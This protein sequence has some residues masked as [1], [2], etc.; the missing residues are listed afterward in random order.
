[1]NAYKIFQKIKTLGM[2]VGGCFIFI[3]MLYITLDVFLRN[4][5]GNSSLHAYEFS[6]YYFMPII[7]FTGLAYTFSAG[8]MPR[9][10]LLV[11]K[12]NDKYQR[13]VA[14]F[15]IILEIVL[16]LLL[17]IFGWQY[18]VY[19]FANGISFSAGGSNFA[20]APVIIFVP[21][22]FLLVMIEM[23]FLLIKNIKGSKASFVVLDEKLKDEVS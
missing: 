14:V 18:A 21:I 19:A 15:L 17:T 10:E 5:T 20:T 2:V 13:I 11:N 23:I 4:V 16:L 6:Q 7:V 1:M 9:V 12:L 22:C 3:M 8:I